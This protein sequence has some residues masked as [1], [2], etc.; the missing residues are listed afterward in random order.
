MTPNGQYRFGD[1][2]PSGV[3]TFEDDSPG[4]CF[5]PFDE[6]PTGTNDPDLQE[7]I[8]R[9][10]S[11]LETTLLEP[12][13]TTSLNAGDGT[14][15]GRFMA[16]KEKEYEATHEAFEILYKSP[17][18]SHLFGIRNCRTYASMKRDRVSG[19]V[20]VF[21][22][23][24]RERWCPMCAGAKAGYAKEQT[25]L[26]IK[27]LEAPRFLTLTLRNC[28]SN[29][30]SQIE[31]LQKSFSTLR[32]RAYWKRNVTGGI[33]FLQVKRGK[34]SN[35][36]HP[37][38]HILLDGNKMEHSRL[39]QLWEQVTFGSPV[40][41]IR[42]VH[43]AEAVS[44]YVARYCARPAV[45]ADMPLADRLEVIEAL[46]GKRLCGTFGTGKVVTLTPPKIE[47]TAEYD[48]IGHYDD[49]VKKAQ[50]NE[51]A[52]RI[53]IAYN[54]Y[55]PLAEDDYEKFTGHSTYHQGMFDEPVYKEKQLLLDFYKRE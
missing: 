31:F 13:E 9:L 26:W 37:H 45:L 11:S 22:D 44:K 52:K 40:I 43:D 34:N 21:S 48:Y 33:W 18:N 38:L 55:Q 2:F 49:I 17:G 50:T 7:M 6:L 41:D 39:S 1:A 27:S 47:S 42:R 23:S 46:V 15:R 36:W 54:T 32:Q 20:V 5:N 25:E 16:G 8:D 24:C 10:K 30:K 4:D 14:Y 3:L 29:L 12:Q 19:D 51:V 53:L 28:E 35:L